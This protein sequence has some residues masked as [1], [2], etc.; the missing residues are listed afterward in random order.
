MTKIFKYPIKITDSQKVKMPINAIILSAG[1]QGDQLNLWAMVE[2]KNTSLDNRVIE[3]Y[4]TGNP[5]EGFDWEKKFIQTVFDPQGFV[6]HIFENI[7]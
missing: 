7:V 2:S 5:I 4:G 6:W 1:F 3:I